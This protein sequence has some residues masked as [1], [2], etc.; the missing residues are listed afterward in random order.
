M[1]SKENIL[2]K[3]NDIKNKLRQYEYE[4]YA[5]E[6]P[7]VSDYEYDMCLKELIDLEQKYPEFKTDDSPSNRVGGHVSEKF[8]KIKHTIPMLSLSNA[9]DVQDILKFDLD[10][11]KAINKIDVSYVVE[12]KIDGLSLSIKYKNGMLYQ[13]VTRGDG[14][15]GED[16][17]ENVK[18]IKNVPLQIEYKN[19]IEIRGEVF[20]F[21]KDFEKINNDIN[22]E[23]KFAN[24]RNAASGSLR[25]LDTKITASRN[26]SAF[27]YFV[28][29]AENYGLKTQYEVIKWLKHHKIP[30]SNDIK[31]FNDIDEVIKRIHELTKLRNE[32]KYD[33]DGIVIK[34]NDFKYYEEIGYTSKFPKW[35]IAYKFPANI[36]RTKLLSI[37]I[38]VGRTGKINYIANV[39][40][41]LLDGS[42]ISKATLHNADYIIEKNIM[43]NDEIELYKAGDVIPKIIKPIIEKRDGTQIPFKTP[44]NCPCCNSVLVKFEN[45]ID[46]Y[47]INDN[48]KDKIIQQ[49][50]HFCTR[51]AMNI[52]GLSEA[53]VTKLYEN[54][55]I[56]SFVD[57]YELKNKKDEI[58]SKDLLIKEKSFN[59]LINAIEKSKV[60]SMEKLLFGLG[61]R[62]VGFNVAKLLSK[63][64]KSIKELSIATNQDIE[65]VG[66]VGTKIANSIT[67]WFA[68]DKN[69]EI[70]WKLQKLNV[71]FNYINEYDHIIVKKEYEI[72]L[73]KSFVITGSFDKN[74]N[75]IKNMLESVYHA[76]VTSSVTKKT[77]FLIIGKNP[78]LSKIEKAKLLNVNII[79]EQFWLN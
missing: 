9:F 62:H 71:N 34:E 51:D 2:K 64:F 57:L 24:A 15:I 28:P 63:R 29:N 79:D 32:L 14:E 20:L 18:T 12:P 72:Y 33:I 23:K 21:K 16:V 30:V 41:V 48:C 49:I 42:S 26:L 45:E 54:N 22:N 19:D 47:C 5:L 68:N 17:T 38:T 73:N 27:F 65:S 75:E 10:I 44:T 6:S 11:K 77:D 76:K 50:T 39:E 56:N 52:E 4:Y 58:L 74:R 3:I 66:E 67:N 31:M 25:N 46:L 37:D 7:S 8:K 13:A 35:A 78:T 70:I 69:L 36:K 59:N 60:N 43:I 1:N 53:I 61:I 55:L 40:P